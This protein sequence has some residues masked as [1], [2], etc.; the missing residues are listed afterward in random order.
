MQEELYKYYLSQPEP[1]KT[2]LLAVRSLI[3]AMD[4]AISETRKYGM[5]CF[6]YIKNIFCY[7]WADKKTAKPYILMAEGRLLRHPE[8][9]SGDRARMKI[10]PMNAAADLPIDTIHAILTEGL[11]L[12][13]DGIV[14]LKKVD[15]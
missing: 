13:K 9:Q 7:L 12:Y 11:A 3:L 6:C 2:C 8:L 10:F 15:A 14:K 5:P 1:I 4:P